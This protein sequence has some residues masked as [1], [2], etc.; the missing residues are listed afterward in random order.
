M[1]AT[2]PPLRPWLIGLGIIAA[3]LAAYLL[4]ADNPWDAARETAERLEAGKRARPEADFVTGLWIAAA[5]NLVVV[6]AL[7]GTVKIWAPKLALAPVENGKFAF[8][9]GSRWMAGFWLGLLAL[10]FLGGSLRYPLASDS[11]WWDELWGIKYGV[12]GY[13][14][15]EEDE[16]LEDRFFAEA[17]WRR[18]LWYYTRP[19]NHPAA[20]FPARISHVIWK[21]FAHPEAPHAFSDFAVRFPNFLASLGAI[22]AVALVGARWGM[23]AG[24]LF[25]GFLL[26]LHPWAIR[27]GID[28]RGYSWVMLWTATGLLWLTFLFRENDRSRWWPWWAFGINQALLV[29]SFPHAVFVALGLFV[30]AVFLVFRGW[31]GRRQRMAAL[32]RLLLVNVAAGM[33]FLQVFAPNLLQMSR[34]LEDVNANHTDH[35]LNGVLLRD[36]AVD[37]ISGR[38]WSVS[39]EAREMRFP[40][41]VGSGMWGWVLIGAVVAGGAWGAVRLWKHQRPAMIALGA[42]VLCGIL[43]LLVFKLAGAFFYPRFAIFLVIPFVLLLGIAG[44]AMADSGRG[45]VRG[46]AAF[47]LM[48]VMAISFLPGFANLRARPFSPMREVAERVKAVADG[49]E[50]PV[51]F[52]CYGHGKEMMPLYAPEARG[53]VTLAELE[54]LVAEAEEKDARLFVAYGYPAFNRAVVPDGFTWL[55]DP[56]RFAKVKSW[57]GIDPD[58]G[59]TLLEWRGETARE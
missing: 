47:L 21:Q 41:F 29:W 27:Y 7:L 39:A 50:R 18:A 24:G 53:A 25:A 45:F 54:A 52:A 33:L 6:L 38:P 31:S 12:V 26:A 20:S 32:G 36:L 15:G 34:W 51:I 44:G 23:P 5:V 8:P 17:N 40:D 46:G 58:A 11:L 19:T 55:D 57:Q 37:L 9:A 43:L 14:I 10:L 28:L 35:S 30:A 2:R 4:L 3:G 48:L 22:A 16:P 59:F 56:T 13:Y 42:L 49:A 1:N